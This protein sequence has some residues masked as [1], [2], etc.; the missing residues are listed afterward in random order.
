MKEKPKKPIADMDE[1]YAIKAGRKKD[2]TQTPDTHSTNDTQTPDD[3]STLKRYDVRFHAATWDQLKHAARDRG[4][5][6]SALIRQIIL[7]WL[8]N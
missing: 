5:S 7:E 2:D 3:R 8:R 1:L 6:V 4:Q